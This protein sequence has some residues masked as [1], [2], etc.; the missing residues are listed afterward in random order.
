[1]KAGADISEDGLYR[2]LLWREWEPTRDQMVWVMLNPSMADASTDDLTITKCMGFA[3]RA[4][5]GGIQVINLYAWRATDPTELSRVPI[6]AE[7]PRNVETWDLV[8]G[9]F[10][11]GPIVAAWGDSKPKGMPASLAHR[12]HFIRPERPP[13]AVCLGK[14]AKGSPKHPSRLG[15]DTPLVVM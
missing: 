2:Y 7:G 14:T 3:R 8:L 10:H 9:Y 11:R 6:E 5:Y 15:Y 12:K 4:G 13:M 1:M